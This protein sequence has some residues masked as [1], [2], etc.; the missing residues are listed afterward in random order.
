M[1]HNHAKQ[2]FYIIFMHKLKGISGMCT[3]WTHTEAL[4]TVGNP[5]P[6]IGDHLQSKASHDLS[7]ACTILWMMA[8]DHPNSG[9]TTTHLTARN[10]LDYHEQARRRREEFQLPNQELI[11]T[12]AQTNREVSIGIDAPL[13]SSGAPP[14]QGRHL[15]RSSCAYHSMFPLFLSV[16]C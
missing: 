13:V 12:R 2:P 6:N 9:Y 5:T 4:F 7:R 1:H 3:S 14:R 11:S 8:G 10:P 15:A 16:T